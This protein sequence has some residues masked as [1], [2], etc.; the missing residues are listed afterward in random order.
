MPVGVVAARYGD[1]YPRQAPSGTPV[2]L[3]GKF[4][5]LVGR[6]SMD[7]LIV[8]LRSQPRANVGDPVVLWG[9]R[10]P[11]EVIA[12]HAGTIPYEILCGVHKRLR[13]VDHG[14]T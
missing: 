9:E 7:M 2:L 1:G 11:V 5:G 13:F 3:N 14:E 4:V 12:Q 8:D 6:A 10:L